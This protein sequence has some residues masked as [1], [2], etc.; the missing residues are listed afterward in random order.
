MPKEPQR[1]N[2]D[3]IP[4]RFDLK[5][6]LPTPLSVPPFLQEVDEDVEKNESKNVPKNFGKEIIRFVKMNKGLIEKIL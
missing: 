5:P 6:Q 1:K 4:V 2:E 3:E